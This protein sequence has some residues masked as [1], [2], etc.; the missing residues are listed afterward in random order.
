MLWSAQLET[1]LSYN[2]PSNKYMVKYKMLSSE[3]ASDHK[4]P[5]TR[6]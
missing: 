1:T 2:Q 6:F 5:V 4:L 3:L